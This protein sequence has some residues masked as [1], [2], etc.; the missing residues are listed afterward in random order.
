MIVVVVIII[1]VVVVVTVVIVVVVVVVVVVVIVVRAAVCCYCILYSVYQH[2][3]GTCCLLKSTNLVALTCLEVNP[4][5]SSVV[6]S[7]ARVLDSST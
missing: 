5:T 3:L 6:Y 4:T 2:H 7:L 1:A